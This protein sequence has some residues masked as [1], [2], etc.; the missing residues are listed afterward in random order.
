M[1]RSIVSRSFQPTSR[2][3]TSTSNY[4]LSRSTMSCCPDE[5]QKPDASSNVE[6]SAQAQPVKGGKK[7]APKVKKPFQQVF[8]E[9]FPELPGV[10]VDTHCHIDSII[11]RFRASAAMAHAGDAEIDSW[12][13]DRLVKDFHVGPWDGCV[14]VC[15]EPTSY[16][17]VM[18]ILD[19]DTTGK[20]RAAFGVHPHEADKWD[21]EVEDKFVK[22]MSHDKVVAWGECGLD[23]YYD[24]SPRDIQ[25]QVFI[26]QIQLA[27]EHGKP[28]VVHTRDAEEDTLEIMTKH[29]PKDWVVHI[30]CCTSSRNMVLPLLAHFPNLY[31]GFTGCI[32]FGTADNIR[33]TL[34]C[35]PLNRLLLE[36]DAPYMAPLPFRGDVAH[37]GMIPFIA[38]RMAQ[39]K[40][41][42]LE[43]LLVQVRENSRNVYGI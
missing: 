20:L 15:C 2:L 36:T 39:E 32:T 12:T 35:V 19:S 23:Y 11:N 31:V 14:T 6:R 33:D 8:T 13:W 7:K 5:S 28:L 38:A 18:E 37:S 42:S 43:E 17:N 24:N 22:A 27:V 21:Q 25:K 3:F 4:S 9:T 40:E 26:R 1:I 16:D 34:R 10:Y 41:V 30:H 29:L